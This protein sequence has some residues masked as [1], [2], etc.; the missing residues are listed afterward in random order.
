MLRLSH[1]RCRWPQPV[2]PNLYN[3]VGRAKGTSPDYAYSESM[4]AAGGD[5]TFADLDAF[6]TKPTDFLGD[7]TKMNKFPG[8]PAAED[9]AAII[10]YLR[11]QSDV[12][13]PLPAE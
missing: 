1:L 7:D 9:R 13:L 8:L 12:P 11:G 6:L 4:L 5:W 10:A 2:G 3:V